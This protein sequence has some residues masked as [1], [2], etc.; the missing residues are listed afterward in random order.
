MLQEAT[1]GMNGNGSCT[2][3]NSINLDT[4]IRSNLNTYL[5]QQQYN[6]QN[7]L[8]T[9]DGTAVDSVHSS[10]SLSAQYQQQS[11]HNQQ[12]FDDYNQ[13]QICLDEADVN[14]AENTNEEYLI[15]S[16]LNKIATC[17]NTDKLISSI[18]DDENT[19]K[20]RVFFLIYCIKLNIIKDYIKKLEKI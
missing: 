9:V 18:S 5:N 6:N 10:F 15:F 13:D 1:N 12:Q 7:H 3:I 19:D 20:V 16:L 8:N 14:E 2:N 17:T 11:N 4:S